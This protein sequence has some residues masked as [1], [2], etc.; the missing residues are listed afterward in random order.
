M[1]VLFQLF[2][3]IRKNTYYGMGSQPGNGKYATVGGG[4]VHLMRRFTLAAEWETLT[5]D[6]AGCG[7][8]KKTDSGTISISLGG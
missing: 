5:A 7:S 1:L 4:K 3:K 8:S 2:Y 6:E